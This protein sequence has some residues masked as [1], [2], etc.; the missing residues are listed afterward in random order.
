VSMPL[1]PQIRRRRDRESKRHRPVGPPNPPPD[2]RAELDELVRRGYLI[3]FFG[4]GPHEERYG[5]NPFLRGG[6]A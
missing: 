4:P 6:A 5:V 1:T 2:L 3:V